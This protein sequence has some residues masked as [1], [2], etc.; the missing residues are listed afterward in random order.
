MNI[1]FFFKY[2]NINADW[3]YKVEDAAAVREVYLDR[4]RKHQQELA[5]LCRIHGWTYLSYTTGDDLITI[6][7]ALYRSIATSHSGDKGS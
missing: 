2:R 4:I 5:S 1:L 7:N 6:L 3:S